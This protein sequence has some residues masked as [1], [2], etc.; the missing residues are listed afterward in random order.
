MLL[1]LRV[2]NCLVKTFEYKSVFE[3]LFDNLEHFFILYFYHAA[4]PSDWSEI[5][6]VGIVCV[7]F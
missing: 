7:Q 2:V 6:L 4:L 5:L 3:N 1:F